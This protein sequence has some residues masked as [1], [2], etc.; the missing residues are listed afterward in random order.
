MPRWPRP[1]AASAR[2]TGWRSSPARKSNKLFNTWLPEETVAAC[3]EYLVSIKGPLTTPDRRR[4]PLAQRGAAADA[5]SVRVPAAGALVQG[6]ALAGQASGEGRHGDLPREHRGHLRRH[7]IRSRHA[8]TTAGFSSCSARPSPRST[9]RSASRRAP[10]SASSRCRSEGSER[11]IRAAIGYAVANK[12]KSLTLVHKGNIMKFT[13][14]AF[15]NWGYQLA[16]REFGAQIYT[17]EQWERT[18]G[19]QG[20]EGSQRRDGRGAKPGASSS[21]TPSPTSRCSRC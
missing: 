9:P 7:R 10:A 12:R 21:R 3:R 5:R 20:R 8:P 1:T 17:W 13:E 16:E 2:S 14:G 18:Q 6:R 19:R 11:L 15:R 4:H